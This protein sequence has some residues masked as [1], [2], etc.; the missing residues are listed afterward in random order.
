MIYK[1]KKGQ[2]SLEMLAIL[3]VIV[4]GAVIAGAYYISSIN[5]N[6]NS[7]D[8]LDSITDQFGNAFEE[9]IDPGNSNGGTDTPTSCGN[10]TC[11]SGDTI[12]NCPEDCGGYYNGLE[13][14]VVEDTYDKD[15]EYEISFDAETNFA[16]N[17]VFEVKL[18]KDLGYSQWGVVDNSYYDVIG[19]S[20]S[21][22]S[23]G[24]KIFYPG[25]ISVLL[26]ILQI[27]N[28][29]FSSKILRIVK[30]KSR[31]TVGFI[32]TAFIPIPLALSSSIFTLNPVDMSIGMSGRISI[33]FRANLSPVIWG[34]VMSDMTRSNTSGFE[35]NSSNA[36][37]G[38]VIALT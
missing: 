35:R 29:Y 13:D 10:G 31:I 36:S 2:V 11:D 3:G 19:G 24:H 16:D 32:T 1:N 17:Y 20:F 33:S 23:L 5:E 22:E 15:S 30:A 4:L 18:Y 25:R 6:V 12:L 8:N 7:G 34:M 26:Q 9:I 38:L 37:S 27:S 14:I 21:D 28:R